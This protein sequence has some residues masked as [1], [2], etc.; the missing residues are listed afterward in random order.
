MKVKGH[1]AQTAGMVAVVTADSWLGRRTLFHKPDWHTTL[2]EAEARVAVMVQA[3]F[4]SLRKHLTNL[5][6]IRLNGATVDDRTALA[7]T[8]EREE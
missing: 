3:K 7:D 1:P 6:F 5:E 2:E 8:A 4:K